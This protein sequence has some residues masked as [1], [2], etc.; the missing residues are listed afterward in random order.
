MSDSAHFSL[1]W[2]C[3]ETK[4]MILELWTT[5]V[6]VQKTT[7]QF[8]S[9]CLVWSAN[10]WIY[11]TIVLWRRQL[12]HDC[13]LNTISSNAWDFRSGCWQ[14][15]W[16]AVISAS[17]CHSAHSTWTRGLFETHVSQ[18]H[19][20][21]LLVTLPCQP[22]VLTSRC[23]TTF[24][25]D[26]WKPECMQTNLTLGSWK[27]TSGP[28]LGPLTDVICEKLVNCLIMIAGMHCMLGRALR[29]HIFLK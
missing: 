4:L 9:Q 24:F 27:S 22:V 10:F 11:W 16:W 7:T 26:T 15:Q 21:M 5:M 14:H 6:C 23:P 3:Q 29:K 1:L 19:H 8:R 12:Y 18:M 2:L 20:L 13:T 25:G 28:K 17:W